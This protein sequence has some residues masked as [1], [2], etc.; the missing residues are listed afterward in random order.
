MKSSQ[1]CRLDVFNES[2]MNDNAE[3]GRKKQEEDED[4]YGHHGGQRVQC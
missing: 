1:I 2:E 3:G 4:E